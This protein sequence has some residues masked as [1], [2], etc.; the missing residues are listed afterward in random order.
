MATRQEIKERSKSQLGNKIFGNAWLKMLLVWLVYD[1]IISALSGTGTRIYDTQAAAVQVGIMVTSLI[2]SVAAIIIGGP[3]RY[4]M[5]RI[6]VKSARENKEA[7]FS[8][9]AA[10]FQECMGDAIVLSILT[11]LFVFLWSLLLIIPGIIKAYA[12]SM[13]VY[14]Q[15]DD[16]EKDWRHCLNKSK[17]MTKGHKWDLFVLDLSFIGWYLVGLLC[18]GIGTYWVVPYHQMAKANFYLELKKLNGEEVEEAP[19]ED[20]GEIP[21]GFDKEA[22]IVDGEIIEDKK[23]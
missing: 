3:L 9:F 16:K 23:D 1:L 5:I 4:G 18:L 19:A 17:E 12:Y 20:D 11:S 22:P 14:I 2:L 13:A 21:D 15:Q 8:D 10:G 7:D 6:T